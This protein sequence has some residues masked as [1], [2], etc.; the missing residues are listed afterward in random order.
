MSKKKELVELQ[1]EIIKRQKRLIESLREEI[2]VLQNERNK[3]KCQLEREV[4]FRE[5]IVGKTLKYPWFKYETVKP[6]E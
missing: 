6:H 2:L 3:A 1:D 4:K 5:S